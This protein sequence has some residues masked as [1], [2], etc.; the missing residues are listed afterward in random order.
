MN[1]KKRDPY[2]CPKCG[3]DNTESYDEEKDYDSI[4]L[5]LS[6][7]DCEH[8]WREYFE[9]KYDGFSDADGEYDAEGQQIM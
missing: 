9:L 5:K 1:A 4:V 2:V 3:S 8:V 6:C 7:C